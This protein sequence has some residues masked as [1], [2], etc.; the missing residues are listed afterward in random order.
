M[1]RVAIALVALLLAGGPASAGAPPRPVCA[2]PDVLDWVAQNLRERHVYA[3]L[4]PRTVR[5]SP[6]AAGD[7]VRCGVCVEVF[8]YDA[9]RYGMT[10]LVRCEAHG[11][12]VRARPN[13]FLILSVD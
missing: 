13:G 3:R 9:D 7:V 4:D 11:Y 10:P 12:V 2:N 6:G 1:I 5:E 8:A